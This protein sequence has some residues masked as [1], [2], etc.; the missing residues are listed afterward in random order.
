VKPVFREQDPGLGGQGIAQALTFTRNPPAGDGT[1]YHHIGIY[2][3]KR[4]ALTR[5]VSL[6]PSPLEKRENLEQLR[7]I[8]AGMRIDV[9]LVDTVPL[10]VDTPEHLEKARKIMANG[11]R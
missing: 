7:A 2:A 11:V 9:A 6:P 4:E 5:F 3:Y 10:G 1:L 8:E